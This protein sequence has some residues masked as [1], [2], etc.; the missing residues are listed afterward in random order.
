MYSPSFDIRETEEAYHLDGELPGV[1][2]N[3]LDIEFRDE[4]CLNIKGHSERETSPTEG[5]WCLSER[6]VGDFRRTFNFPSA[7]DQE[8]THAH[9]KDGIL[10]LTVPKSGATGNTK[11]VVV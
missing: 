10:S 9:L 4:H 8:H 1:Q 6:S 3:D 5:S 2:R 7:V 11:K